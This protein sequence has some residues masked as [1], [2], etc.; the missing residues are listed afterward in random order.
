MNHLTTITTQLLAHIPSL[1]EEAR[2]YK[3]NARRPH[4][5]R[6]YTSG[7]RNF[8]TWCQENGFAALPAS[9]ATIGLYLTSLASTHTA[10]TVNSRKTAIKHMHL[11]H[12]IEHSPTDH[13]DVKQI[14][15]GIIKTHGSAQK[16]KK[17]ITSSILKRM[18]EGSPQT[19][20]W[21]RNR[22]LLLLTYIG[23]FRRS[24][25]VSL[26]VEDCTFNEQ[27]LAARLI[28]SKGDKLGAGVT[29]PIS[30]KKDI[31]LCPV[32]A[33]EH[34][35]RLADI[36]EGAIFPALNKNG[37]PT[38]RPLSDQCVALIIKEAVARVGLDSSVFSGH[39]MRRGSATQGINAG[40][41]PKEVQNH[42]RHKSVG[43]TMRYIEEAELFKDN[44]SEKL[45]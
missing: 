11:E 22:A 25:V 29:V 1:I 18:L 21:V 20:V 26:R 42:L 13:P 14:C 36:K 37:E 28:R 10:S 8:A 17:A 38:K 44:L 32:A 45:L 40:M 4:T 24:E 27:G 30:R 16:P 19:P 31:L 7:W 5:R 33:L 12:G 9:P 41:N 23:A 34:W 15:M 6:S 43:M 39:S 2:T 35:L 3:V